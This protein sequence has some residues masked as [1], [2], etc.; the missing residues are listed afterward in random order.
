MLFNGVKRA[1]LK[2]NGA[3]QIASR[4]G[5]LVGAR[6]FDQRSFATLIMA[7]HLEG[8]LNTQVGSCLTAAKDLGDPD[9]S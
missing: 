4:R 7:E 3:M 5:T 6:P 9:V 2:N 8:D 1:L